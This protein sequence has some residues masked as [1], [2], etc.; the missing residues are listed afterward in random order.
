MCRRRVP[1]GQARS[2][3][4]HNCLQLVLGHSVNLTVESLQPR[5]Q[6]HSC[7][8]FSPQSPTATGIAVLLEARTHLTAPLRIWDSAVQPTTCPPQA[9]SH[10]EPFWIG[11]VVSNLH[12]ASLRR[13]NNLV[14]RI[15]TPRWVTY[16]PNG[17]RNRVARPNSWPASA[18]VL[19]CV[20]HFMFYFWSLLKRKA[21]EGTLN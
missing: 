8:W 11:E 14:W 13:L 20:V 6:E 17:Q 4:R 1:V 9:N 3:D 19:Y 2:A 12:A 10:E 7:V 18:S 16:L 21:V 5:V 15:P